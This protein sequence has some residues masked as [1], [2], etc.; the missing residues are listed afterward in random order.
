MTKLSDHFTLEEFTKSQ[1][2]IRRGINNQP[3]STQTDRLKLL[4]QKV[5]E[6]VRVHHRKPVRISSGF[7]SESLNWAIGGSQT[8]QHSK[9]EAA[10]FEIKG[11]SNQEVAEWIR[12]NLEFDQLI[13]EGAKPDDPNAGWIH[14]SYSKSRA[15]QMAMTATFIGG[16]AKYSS[17]LA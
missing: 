15:R 6:P 9:G 3:T 1:T 16:R 2:A 17:G 11:V 14:V 10:D 8:S 13:L 7:R 12:D 5:L 4:C